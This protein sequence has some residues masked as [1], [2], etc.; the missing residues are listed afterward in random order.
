MKQ[1]GKGEKIMYILFMVMMTTNTAL[2]IYDRLYKKEKD[3][4][5]KKEQ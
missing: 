5:C 1:M 2:A 3:C 4:K